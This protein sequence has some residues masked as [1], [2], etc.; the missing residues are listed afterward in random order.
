MSVEALKV[1]FDAVLREDAAPILVTLPFIRG[2][3]CGSRAVAVVVPAK[4]MGLVVT[5]LGWRE[6]GG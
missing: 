2:V 3:Q 6:V 1:T 5:V 4:M